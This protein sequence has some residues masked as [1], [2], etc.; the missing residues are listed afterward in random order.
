MARVGAQ[1]SR[2]ANAVWLVA[3]VPPQFLRVL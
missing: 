2:S 3:E 1:F